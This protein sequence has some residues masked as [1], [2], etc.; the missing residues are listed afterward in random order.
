MNNTRYFPKNIKVAIFPVPSFIYPRSF[1]RRNRY[2]EILEENLLYLLMQFL[3]FK[4]KFALPTVIEHGRLLPD[5]NWTGVI[6]IIQREEADMAF[7][8]LLVTEERALAVDFSYPYSFDPLTF[9]AYKERYQSNPYAVFCP[10]S[11]SLWCAIFIFLG[12]VSLVYYKSKNRNDNFQS[13]LFVVYKILID[14]STK[15]QFKKLSLKFLMY[16]WILC[17][18]IITQ[19]Y[20]G[21]LLSFL[22]FPTLTGIRDISQLAKASESSSFSCLSFKGTVL[23]NFIHQSNDPSFNKIAACL[24]RSKQIAATDIKKIAQSDNHESAVIVPRSLAMPFHQY[25]YISKD[26]FYTFVMAIAVRKSFCCKDAIDEMIHKISAAGILDK[27]RRDRD[28]V[29]SH[30][31]FVKIEEEENPD[32]Q[33]SLI[34]VAGSFIVLIFGHLLACSVFILEVILHRK[35]VISA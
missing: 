6:G 21:L 4:S 29:L 16:F 13:G 30:A 18:M 14:Q 11:L 10:F 25:F 2:M 12:I 26:D 22:T 17:T 19:S 31:D 1:V 28:F 20:K 27:F 8:T 32:R 34:D 24:N 35:A 7:G 3:N 15:F 9:V 5:G 33:L 23:T